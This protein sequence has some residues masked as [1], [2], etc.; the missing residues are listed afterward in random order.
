[1]TDTIEIAVDYKFSAITFLQFP[2]RLR[3]IGHVY[4]A[5]N[6]LELR[7]FAFP[8]YNIVDRIVYLP[9]S[10]REQDQYAM[11]CYSHLQEVYAAIKEF[12]ERHD[13]NFIVK[14][15]NTLTDIFD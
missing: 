5:D 1:M 2:K 10:A 12:C 8:E 4:K 7:S 9:G 6:E 3:N 15:R 14:C 11:R 13:I